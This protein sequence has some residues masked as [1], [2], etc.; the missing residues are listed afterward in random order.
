M[1]NRGGGVDDKKLVRK[2]II[3]NPYAIGSWLIVLDSRQEDDQEISLAM[4]VY[5]DQKVSSLTRV[6]AAVVA[7][8]K[9]KTAADFALKEIS[10]FMSHYGDMDYGLLLTN[11]TSTQAGK[12]EYIAFH[13]QLMLV[14]LLQ[15]FDSETAERLSLKGLKTK[16]LLIRVAA[17][18]VAATRWP[19]QLIESGQGILSDDEYLTLLAF[20][21][22]KHPQLADEIMKQKFDH[23]AFND[24]LKRLRQYGAPG[25]FPIGTILFEY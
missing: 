24:A 3:Q 18:V 14:C 15:Y 22:L 8:K 19:E 17:G 4:S 7:A 16:N 25:V 13:N 20:A 21:S 6:A 2:L 5:R 9:D 11:L 23:I 10:E 1:L 12:T